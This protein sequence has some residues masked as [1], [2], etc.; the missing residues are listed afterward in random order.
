H[1]DFP[2]VKVY[3]RYEELLDDP[4][5]DLVVIGTPLDTHKELAVAAAARKKQ[6][7]VDKI[8][9]L[10]VA[11]ADEMI[12]AAKA[13]GVLLSVFQCRRWDSD[14]LTVKKALARGW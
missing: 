10:S 6:I 11:E 5:I 1:A 12:R 7:V 2:G 13:H 8:M 4:G 14:F 9:A 3:A